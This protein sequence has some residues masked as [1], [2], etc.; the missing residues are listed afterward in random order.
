[1]R[2][3]DE[4]TLLNPALDATLGFFSN[5][6][7]AEA[8]LYTLD[9]VAPLVD[10]LLDA[11]DVSFFLTAEDPSVGFTFHSRTVQDPIWETRW[12]PTLYLTGDVAAQAVPEPATATLLL[13]GLLGALGRL[14]R[15]RR[16]P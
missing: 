12:Y 11:G 6:L 2:Y 1:V 14:R 7:A 3:A 15:S 5:M 4:A 10:D 9:L 13:V 8:H 16:T